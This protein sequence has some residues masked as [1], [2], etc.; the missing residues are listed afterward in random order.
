MASKSETGIAV[1]VSEFFTLISRCQ[2]Y[3]TR[4]NPS[5]NAIKI[6][7][8]QVVYNNAKSS[9]EAFDVAKAPYIN[10]VN[11]RENFL[12]DDEKFATRIVN[13][14][15][16]SANIKPNQVADVHTYNRKIQGMR[17][18]KKIKNPLP[19]D[20]KQISASQQSHTQV[21]EHFTKLIDLVATFPS[22]SPNETELQLPSLNTWLATFKTHNTAVITATTPMLDAMEV[23]NQAQFAPETG[24]VD[25]AL[26]VKKYVKS[27]KAISLAEFRKISGLKFRRLPKKH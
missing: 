16:A 14:V 27:V 26:A 22:Y 1:N 10:A 15:E 11:A 9:L 24:L 25:I 8:L 6:P 21:A 20:A 19:D 3:G 12:A 18:D 23:R 17:K 7:N 4:Y 5:N 2:G 13:A